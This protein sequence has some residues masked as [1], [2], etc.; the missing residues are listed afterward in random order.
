MDADGSNQTM[1]SMNTLEESH[2]NVVL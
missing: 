2:T 1:F